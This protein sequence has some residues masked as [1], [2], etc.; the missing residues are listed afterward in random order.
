MKERDMEFWHSLL[1]PRH[2]RKTQFDD[3]RQTKKKLA[4]EKLTLDQV[5]QLEI[6]TARYFCS[7]NFS[8]ETENLC[9]ISGAGF[10]RRSLTSFVL[11]SSTSDRFYAHLM[12]RNRVLEGCVP[13]ETE[14]ET[15]S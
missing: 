2:R 10:R 13:R 12:E 5:G 7:P 1:Q 14:N 3:T 11:F 15:S 4:N 8:P 9:S 6:R